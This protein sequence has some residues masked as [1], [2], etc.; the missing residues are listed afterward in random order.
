MRGSR[1][2]YRLGWAACF[3]A[4]T[5]HARM[6]ELIKTW[7]AVTAGA[8]TDREGISAETRIDR[9]YALAWAQRTDRAVARTRKAAKTRAARRAA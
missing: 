7:D 6:S 5:L 1:S 8:I 2:A 9:K 3:A 4:G